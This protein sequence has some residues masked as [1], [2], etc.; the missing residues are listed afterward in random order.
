MAPLAFAVSRSLAAGTDVTDL[1]RDLQMV[2]DPVAPSP[3]PGSSLDPRL[4]GVGFMDIG[5]ELETAMGALRE[6]IPAAVWYLASRRNK[7]LV[8][9]TRRMREVSKGTTE[10]WIKIGTV[11][12]AIE[13]A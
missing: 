9:W 13:V 12:D 6:H 2:A 7:D 10:I 4:I 1:N 8:E 5:A 11:T 3:F